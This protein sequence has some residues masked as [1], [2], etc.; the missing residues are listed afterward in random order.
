MLDAFRRT[1]LVVAILALVFAPSA[2]AAAPTTILVKFRQPGGSAAKIEALGDH[3]L[4]RTANGVS[5]VRIAPGESA[6]ARIAAYERR[7][8]SVYAEPN[9]RV[10][11]LALNA[12]NDTLL[13]GPVG[14]CSHRRPGRLESLPGHVRGE[15]RCPARRRR[16]RR[17]CDPSRP[18]RSCADR[19]R[20]QLPELHAVRGRPRNRRRLARNARRRNR[21]G[22]NQQRCRGRRRPALPQ[23]PPLARRIGPAPPPRHCNTSRSTT[24]SML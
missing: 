7:A 6:G 24:R 15:C 16:L 3:A 18:G 2:A 22:R 1:R 5:V 8:A 12:P 17:G 21:R 9:G 20:C 19:P 13:R 10:Y 11:A 23:L 14:A 4:S